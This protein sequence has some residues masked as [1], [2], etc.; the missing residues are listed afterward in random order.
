VDASTTSQSEIAAGI[1]A[2][3]G[4]FVLLAL[5]S[6][7]QF[8]D[9]LKPAARL[10]HATRGNSTS[11][12]GGFPVLDGVD[13]PI[14][15]GK[16][17]SLLLVLDL[18][19]LSD[20]DV[21]FALAHDG[22][23]NFFYDAER[24]PWGFEGLGSGSCAVI[25]TPK[26]L[27]RSVVAPAGTLEFNEVPIDLVQMLTHPQ[28]GHVSIANMDYDDDDGWEMLD[29]QLIGPQWPPGAFHRIGGWP[30]M[31]QESLH[32]ICFDDSDKVVL[33][34]LDCDHEAGWM[35]GDS[36]VLYFVID[37]DSLDKQDFTNTFV[38]LQC[39]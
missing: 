12:F 37:R 4:H 15:R 11:H 28:P 1:L 34:Q 22:L 31:V 19:E 6:A 36:G 29:R 33:L 13:W 9:L 30:T 18:G 20:I 16:P 2:R 3:N 38:V 21:G 39:C 10:T 26:G 25:H 17:L 23:L 7:D 32:G 8:C 27:G 5:A 14:S 35:W 24:Q